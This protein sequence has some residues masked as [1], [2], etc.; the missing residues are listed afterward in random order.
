[1]VDAL[2][3]IFLSDFEEV[4]EEN[5]LP[6]L[7]R[8]REL[9]VRER[10][11]ATLCR[12]LRRSRRSWL[13]VVLAAASIFLLAEVAI[14]TYL[15]FLCV[16]FCFFSFSVFVLGLWLDTLFEGL[17]V[18]DLDWHQ[19]M[20]IDPDL[21][22]CLESNDHLYF[23]VVSE[24]CNVMAGLRLFKVSEIALSLQ[25]GFYVFAVDK[26]KGCDGPQSLSRRQ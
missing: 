10:R 9:L 26:E 17:M 12:F 6:P 1:M 13:A 16:I 15:K 5:E 19:G 2:T 4:E 7:R 22:T 11:T 3:G 21:Y 8:M 25:T 24:K 14:L 23:A 18:K 20:A